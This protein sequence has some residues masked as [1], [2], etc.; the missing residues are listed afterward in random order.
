MLVNG[1]NMKRKSICKIV[2]FEAAHRLHN[3]DLTEKENLDLYGPCNSLHGHT[4]KLECCVSG[5]VADSGFIMNFKDLK[6]ILQEEVLDKYDHA[7]LN[8]LLGN[9]STCENQI[10]ILWA[11]I[12]A[13]LTTESIRL[14]Q[15]KLW[16]TPTSFCVLSRS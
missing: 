10:D 12:S 2:T 6:K 9:L 14:E 8:D 1:G 5:P 13:K 15:L 11:D 16:E 4:Y 7:Y 3:P